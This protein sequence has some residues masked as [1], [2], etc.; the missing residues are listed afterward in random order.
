[1]ITKSKQDWSV[2]NMIKVGFMSLRVIANRATPG[3]FK[4]DAYLLFSKGNFY[5]FV[6]HNGLNKLDENELA[7]DWPG[8]AQA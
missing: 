8:H 4:P 2:G 3:D 5:E 1:M 6:P 7:A